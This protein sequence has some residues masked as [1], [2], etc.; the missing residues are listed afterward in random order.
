[1]AADTRPG[2]FRVLYGDEDHLLNLALNEVQ[3]SGTREIFRFDGDGLDA[4]ELVSFCE[5]RTSGLRGVIV[6]EA[7]KIKSGDALLK[8]IEDRNPNDKSVFLLFVFRTDTLKEAWA[9]AAVD[10]GRVV[11]HVKPK[12]WETNKQIARIHDEAKRVGVQLGDGVPE[13]LLKFLGYDLSL[14]ANEL[15]KAAYLVGDK[16]VVGKD[17]ILS[18]IP[19]IFP[20]QPHEVAEAAASKRPKQAMT[21][22]G[23]VY[24]NMGDGASIPITYSLMRL[25]EKLL[26][27]RNLSDVGASTVEVSE[28]L[29]MNEY[30]YK[31]NLLPLVR[32]HTV[33]RLANQMKILCKLDALVKGSASSKR[34]HVELAVL[35]LAT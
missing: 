26:I 9:K 24:R 29:G 21:L 3:S 1:M 2:P 7:Q 8:F 13:L 12:P 32:R 18:L 34:T 31:M 27:A 4:N 22:L 6:D 33:S 35:S 20:T 16:K 11:R 5:S 25:V 28:R 19:Q 15:Q 30:A 23:F 14:I 17:A 10:R